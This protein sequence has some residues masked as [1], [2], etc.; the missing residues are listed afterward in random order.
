LFL[1]LRLR[2]WR[3]DAFTVRLLLRWSHRTFSLRCT[4]RTLNSLDALLALRL[5]NY[6]RLST[7]FDYA[8][9]FRR[10]RLFRFRCRLRLTL[11]SHLKLLSLGAFRR[12][13]CAGNHWGVVQLARDSRRNVD[14]AAAPS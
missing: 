14:L 6:V 3:C 5:L 11:V 7:L 4:S 9:L 12:R 2:A 13:R 8:R 10:S 1:L